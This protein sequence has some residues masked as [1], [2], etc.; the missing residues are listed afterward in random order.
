[1]ATSDSA[2][3]GIGADGRTPDPSRYDLV[4]AVIPLVL[5]ASV[6]AGHLLPVPVESALAAAAVVA[7][8]VVADALFFNP[9]TRGRGQ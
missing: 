2:P 8:L 1:M 9:P 5:A 4:L 6:A 3:H 7:T